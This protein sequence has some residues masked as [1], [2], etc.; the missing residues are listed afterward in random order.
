MKSIFNKN[1]KRSVQPRKQIKFRSNA[2]N[3][4]RIKFLSATLDKPL[5]KKHERR[6]IEIR[7]GDE[8]LVM[9]GKFKKKKGKITKVDLK[10]SK[11]QIEGL[12]REKKG[13]EKLVTWF[14]PSILK[15]TSLDTSDNKRL[16]SKNNKMETKKET[17][18]VEEKAKTKSEEKKE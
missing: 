12:Q 6:N 8:V 5:R 1:W 9:R 3:H 18:K 13:G 15:I 4:I 10:N 7:K 16:K 17:K 14:N 11:V 2:P